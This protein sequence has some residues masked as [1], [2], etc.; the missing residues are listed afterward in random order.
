MV[1][2]LTLHKSLP[3]GVILGS[4]RDENL[5]MHLINEG[6]RMLSELLGVEGNSMK[7]NEVE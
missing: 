3:D 7:S 5:C 4:T 1:L 6:I 2:G